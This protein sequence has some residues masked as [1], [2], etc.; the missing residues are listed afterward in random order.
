MSHSAPQPPI[1][2]IR[3]LHVSIHG[4][5]DARPI[6][7]GLSVDIP[8]GSTVALLG[9]SGS[10]KTLAAYAVLNVLPRVAR[11]DSGQIL[12]NGADLRTMQIGRA[13]V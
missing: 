11:L 4:R 13:H 2:S 10:G 1:L 8:R 6:L 9:E 12:F 3:D 5:T 7:K